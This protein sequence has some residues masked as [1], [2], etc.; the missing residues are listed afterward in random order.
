MRMRSHPPRGPP[1]LVCMCCCC[2]VQMAAIRAAAGGLQ[3][4]DI[5]PTAGAYFL[6]TVFHAGKVHGLLVFARWAAARWL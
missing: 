3:D 2:T 6:P 1:H 5:S 4:L